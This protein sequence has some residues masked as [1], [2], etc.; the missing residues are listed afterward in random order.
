MYV[1]GFGADHDSAHLQMIAVAAESPFIYV[2]E[3]DQVIDAFG[4]AIGALQGT[5]LHTYYCDVCIVMCI[6]M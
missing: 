6:Y 2:E 3:T 5:L 4:G 1:F